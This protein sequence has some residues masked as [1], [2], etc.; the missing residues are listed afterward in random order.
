MGE[1]SPSSSVDLV[2]EDGGHRHGNFHNYYPFHPPVNRLKVLQE[3]GILDYVV[4]FA[5]ANNKKRGHRGDTH[6]DDAVK[7]Q[8][9]LQDQADHPFAAKSANGSE[10]T[11][12]I[13]GTV[14]TQSPQKQTRREPLF[15][16]CDLG[17]NEG[18]LTAGLARELTNR[19]QP[20]KKDTVAVVDSLGLD[21]D[22]TLIGRA[23][24]NHGMLSKNMPIQFQICNLCQ[25]LDHETAYRN[26]FSGKFDLTS[27]F[28]T[29][30]WIHV[31]A[32]DNGLK[33]FLHRACQQTKLLLIEPQPSKCYRSARV[34]LERLGRP[35]IPDISFDRLKM[36]QN[37]EQEIANV[38]ISCGFQRVV[39]VENKSNPETTP[40]S[41][42]PPNNSQE[43]ES[44]RTVWKR[45]LQLYERITDEEE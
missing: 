1:T 27:I 45:A 30:M 15:R 13:T 41:H 6:T 8:K 22:A 11:A 42:H 32:G 39:L 28:S 20:S 44:N 33:D 38:I 34:R 18:D 31:H 4:Q 37:I 14:E 7:R 19:I 2:S 21:M 3:T 16:Y 43:E 10:N 23:R 5:T 12:T 35:D 29:T 9:C 26:H 24:E 40:A 36:R 17:C 25:A